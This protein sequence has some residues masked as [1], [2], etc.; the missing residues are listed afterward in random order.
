LA[1]L[2]VRFGL[3]EFAAGLGTLS[4][5]AL[6]QGVGDGDYCDNASLIAVAKSSSIALLFFVKACSSV[7]Q[8]PW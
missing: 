7:I 1:G 4:W 8:R 2:T 3:L 5:G 6:R